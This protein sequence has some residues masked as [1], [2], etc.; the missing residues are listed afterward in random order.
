[1]QTNHSKT[2]KLSAEWRFSQKPELTIM[3]QGLQ[4][5]LKQ[6]ASTLDGHFGMGSERYCFGEEYI[7]FSSDYRLMAMIATIVRK[8][9]ANGVIEEAC[10]W[11][12]SLNTDDFGKNG[13]IIFS[14]GWVMTQEQHEK[15]A[16]YDNPRRLEYL[17]SLKHEG[18]KYE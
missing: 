13:T 4:R 1:M 15:L 8:A 3:S 17:T 7:T 12:Q 9:E 2:G 6:A 11:I 10:M 18:L 14:P 5:A 16:E